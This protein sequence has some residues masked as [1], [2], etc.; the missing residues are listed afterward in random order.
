[1]K[2]L[3]LIILGVC[4]Y[5]EVSSQVIYLENGFSLTSTGKYLEKETKYQL[6]LGL[7]YSEHSFYFLSSGL[8]YMQKGN[9]LNIINE[10]N[11]NISE[12]I[13]NRYFSLNTTFNLR[14]QINLIDLYIGCGPRLDFRMNDKHIVDDVELFQPV[15]WGL[16]CV[17]GINCNFNRWCIGFCF[18]Y[19]PSF[20]SIYK[21]ENIKD[22]TVT[23]GITLGYIL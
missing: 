17:T 11:G 19:L 16:K 23:F 20:T 2:N 9:I 10:E 5:L 12:K 15:L 18:N 22:R 8:S 3:W 7:N 14:K 6:G 1:M 13:K 4:S 21:N